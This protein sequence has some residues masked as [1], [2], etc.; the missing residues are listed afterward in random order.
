MSGTIPMIGIQNYDRLG[1]YIKDL[2]LGNQ[3]IPTTIAGFVAGA[4]A[5]LTIPGHYTAIQFVQPGDHVLLIKLPNKALLEAHLARVAANAGYA[6]P[7]FYPD[8]I[9]QPQSAT[10]PPPVTAGQSAVAMT[11]P[12]AVLFD[13]CRIGDYTISNCG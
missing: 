9:P 4:S 6:T 2:A 13:D 10:N 8:F 1:Q 5:G 12:Q 7:A 3:P 11:K